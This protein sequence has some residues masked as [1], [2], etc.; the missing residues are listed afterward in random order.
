LSFPPALFEAAFHGYTPLRAATL[1]QFGSPRKPE[2]EF[3]TVNGILC[4]RDL[5]VRFLFFPLGRYDLQ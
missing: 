3:L 2:R 1:S 5:Q 4:C